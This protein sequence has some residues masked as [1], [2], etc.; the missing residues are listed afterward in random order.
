M[1]ENTGIYGYIKVFITRE[2][3]VKE[4]VFEDKNA[5]QAN[6]ANMIVDALDTGVGFNY[7]MDNLFNG[8]TNLGAGNDG[9]DGI[10]IYDNVGGLWY[11]MNMTDPPVVTKGLVGAGYGNVLWVGTFTGA[12]IT[13]ANANQVLLGSNWVNAGLSFGAAGAEVIAKPSSWASQAV[14]ITETLTIEWTIKHQST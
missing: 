7:S 11:E 4:L 6:Y 14:L 12:G 9:E 3:G 10:A 5:I 1:K 8:N 13:V 2:N